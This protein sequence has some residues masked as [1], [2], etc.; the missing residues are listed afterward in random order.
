[1]ICRKI[2]Q[3]VG[4]QGEVPLH[5]SSVEIHLK[6]GPK[7]SVRHICISVCGV[8]LLKSDHPQLLFFLSIRFRREPRFD[9]FPHVEEEPSPGF[10]ASA[11]WK[12]TSTTSSS[13]PGSRKI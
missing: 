1:M 13:S 12:L 9:N 8:P 10:L 6:S 7:S 2:K 4:K 5:I 3:G 11:T